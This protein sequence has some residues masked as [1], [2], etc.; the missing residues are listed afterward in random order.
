MKC[1]ATV[2][3]QITSSYQE[4]HPRDRIVTSERCYYD[5]T[6]A[7]IGRRALRLAV[8]FFL[9]PFP[10]IR[11]ETSWNWIRER[12]GGGGKRIPGRW[13]RERVSRAYWLS[14]I[15]TR[16]YSMA[17]PLVSTL[18]YISG[19]SRRSRQQVAVWPSFSLTSSATKSKLH[20]TAEFAPI[21]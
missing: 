5:S 12:G 6:R 21:G 17:V 1:E 3:V 8:A 2:D 14:F 11:G 4:K 9:P 16:V 20:W 18:P 7:A 15:S 19:L 10:V 13:S